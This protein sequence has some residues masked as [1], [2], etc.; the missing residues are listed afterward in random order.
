MYR[1]RFLLPMLLVGCA[2]VPIGQYPESALLECQKTASEY[3][4]AERPA[5]R[6]AVGA[7]TGA[8]ADR[9]LEGAAFKILGYTAPLSIGSF[10]APLAVYGVGIGLIEAVDRK[11][12]IVRL[13]LRDKGHKVY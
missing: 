13:C 1:M 11:D 9:A 12:E 7:A 4:M 10:I 8:L 3:N 5:M 6:G 2:S